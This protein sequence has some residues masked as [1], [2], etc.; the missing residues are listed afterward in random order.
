[1]EEIP[2]DRQWT[3]DSQP[4]SSSKVQLLFRWP[5]TNFAPCWSRP[6][7]F[8]FVC[9]CFFVI[10]ALLIHN[11]ILF[12]Y[13]GS[14]AYLTSPLVGVSTGVK[15]MSYYSKSNTQLPAAHLLEMFYV[16]SKTWTKNILIL[17][18]H[19]KW[20]SKIPLICCCSSCVQLKFKSNKKAENVGLREQSQIVQWNSAMA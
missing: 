19:L 4:N 12:F 7:S 14:K 15:V 3:V 11:A 16:C 17:Y 1:M 2:D 20:F 9:Y 18:R 5:R 6:W 8:R 10:W 13:D